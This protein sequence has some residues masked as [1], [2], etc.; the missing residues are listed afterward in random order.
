MILKFLTLSIVFSMSLFAKNIYLIDSSKCKVYF[1]QSDKSH[2]IMKDFC[3]PKV[4]EVIIDNIKHSYEFKKRPDIS[5]LL[6]KMR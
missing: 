5:S 1:E 6:Y 2:I 3:E 4:K